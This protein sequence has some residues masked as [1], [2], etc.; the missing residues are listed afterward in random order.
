M[1]AIDDFGAGQ[2]SLTYLRSF[3][4]TT[5]RSTVHSWRPWTVHVSP[6]CSFIRWLP[7]ARPWGS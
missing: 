5:S 1:I 4:S 7:W 2:S 6:P 3:P